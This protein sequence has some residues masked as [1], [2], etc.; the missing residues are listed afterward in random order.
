MTSA[1]TDEAAASPK[2]TVPPKAAISTPV[3]DGPIMRPACQ[4]IEP[5]AMAFGS[6]SRATICGTSDMRLGSSKARKVLLS[7]AS[8]SR[9]AM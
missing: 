4:G 3:I 7:A 9:C 1:R 6:R 8:A 5:S 2:P